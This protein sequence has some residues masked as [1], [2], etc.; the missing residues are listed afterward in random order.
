MGMAGRGWKWLDI[1]RNGLKWLSID[2]MPGNGWKWLKV[3][4]YGYR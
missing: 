2:G 1:T 4:G 3:S